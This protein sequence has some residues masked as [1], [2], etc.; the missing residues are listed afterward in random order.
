M[1][2][3]LRYKTPVEYRKAE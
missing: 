2:G 1:H 3:S